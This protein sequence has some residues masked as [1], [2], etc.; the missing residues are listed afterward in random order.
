M[1]AP[2]PE[3]HVQHLESESVGQNESAT[4]GRGPRESGMVFV[5][6]DSEGRMPRRRRPPSA[7]FDVFAHLDGRRVLQYWAGSHFHRGP[8]PEADIP[9][10]RLLP[11]QQAYIPLGFRVDLPAGVEAQLRSHPETIVKNGATVVITEP[12]PAAAGDD[13]DGEWTVLIRNDGELTL[14]V[15]HGD[16]VATVVFARVAAGA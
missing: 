5:P 12:V 4:E 6:S 15:R 11:G 9:C 2:A 13:L 10:I 14:T 3:R 16:P 1:T 8:D 7:G